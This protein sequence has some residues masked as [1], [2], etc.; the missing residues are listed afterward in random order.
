MYSQDLFKYPNEVLHCG[1]SKMKKKKTQAMNLCH[2]KS[3]L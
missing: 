3:G 1:W 2:I